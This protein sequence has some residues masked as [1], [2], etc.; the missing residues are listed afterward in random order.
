VKRR[1]EFEELWEP[2]HIKPGVNRGPYWYIVD[3]PEDLIARFEKAKAEMEAVWRELRE[4]MRE[5]LE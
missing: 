3:L 4:A 2:W 5:E 1:V